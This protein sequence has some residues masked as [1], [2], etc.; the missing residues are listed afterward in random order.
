LALAVK[1]ISTSLITDDYW[2]KVFKKIVVAV[3]EAPQKIIAKLLSLCLSFIGFLLDKVVWIVHAIILLYVFKHLHILDDPEVF[4]A[5]GA[6][7]KT[8]QLKAV[9]LLFGLLLY[10][11]WKG[12]KSLF[13]KN[14][15][16]QELPAQTKE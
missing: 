10:W 8:K 1:S 11:V 7:E 4:D 3:Y 15:K 16:I 5:I 9:T 2:R 14:K 6:D 13:G 12:L